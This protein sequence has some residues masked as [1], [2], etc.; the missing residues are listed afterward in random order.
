M[1]L[2][3][4]GQTPAQKNSKQMALNR[5]TGAM[6]PVSNPIVKR[7]QSAVAKELA[8]L[9]QRDTFTDR[10]EIS[11]MFYVKDKRRRDIDNMIASI[12]DALVKAGIII[13]DSWQCL[14]ISEADAQID[15]DNPRAELVITSIG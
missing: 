8:M 10:V 5:R 14:R 1:K 13:D 11:Y 6:F 2:T 12:N 9:Y 7:W 3:L 4:T 15:I